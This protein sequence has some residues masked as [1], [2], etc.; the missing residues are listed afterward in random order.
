MTLALFIPAIWSASLLVNLRKRHVYGNPAV[1]NTDYEGEISQFGDRVK[2][3]NIGAVTVF[4]YT[5][6]TDM[7]VPETLTDAQRELV[8]DQAK[9][10]N[11]QIDDLD[12][13][14]QKPKLMN[15]ATQEAAYAL[16]DVADQFLGGFYADAGSELGTH[17]APLAP[18]ADPG[19]AYELIVDA[20]VGLDELNIP[21]EGRTAVVPPWF[22]GLIEKDQRF[23]SSGSEASTSILRAGFAGDAN[24]C[25]IVKS[26]NVPVVN[27][28]TN[29]VTKIQVSTVQARSYAEQIVKTEAYSPERRFGDAL[30]GLHVYGGKVVREEALVTVHLRRS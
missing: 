13:R 14:Q 6:N 30:K 24:G 19:E 10:F 26:N 5:R 8:I 18:L 29:D 20:N 3:N 15:A 21:S 4:T 1:T 7:P 11:F 12:T 9:G 17:A 23:V 27:N 16:A 25:A 28:G 22:V 2:I